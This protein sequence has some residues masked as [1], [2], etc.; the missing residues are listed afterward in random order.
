MRSK[1]YLNMTLA[2]AS[3]LI[4]ASAISP[5][6]RGAPTAVTEKIL[7]FNEFTKLPVPS[8]VMARMKASSLSL[9]PIGNAQHLPTCSGVIIS[10]SGYVLT[11]FHCIYGKNR[12]TKGEISD[13]S[14]KAEF[15]KATIL[16]QGNGT[17]TQFPH[18]K[19]PGFNFKK[20]NEI[21]DDWAIL[22]LPER[23]GGYACSQASIEASEGDSMYHLGFPQEY[24][25]NNSWLKAMLDPAQHE[26]KDKNL[27]ALRK[28]LAEEFQNA[29][30]RGESW[31]MNVAYPLYI[32]LGYNFNSVAA[33]S[34]R[35]PVMSAQSDLDNVIDPKNYGYSTAPIHVGMS[36][37]GAFS[38]DT[39]HLVGLN[40]FTFGDL[41][42]SYA[43]FPYGIGFIKVSNVKNAI[44]KKLGEKLVSQAFDCNPAPKK[45]ATHFIAAE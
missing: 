1:F 23:P 12:N 4:I 30:K 7:A 10:N 8:D 39:G 43:G 35:M 19:S 16:A 27:G 26:F 9:I 18:S 44:R 31:A 45:A 36:G 37:G 33:A 17:Y 34:K 41:R 29:L 40:V 11:D 13:L 2:G 14:P 3:A 42:M 22:K 6:A 21:F 24:T 38:V 25:M 5:I 20:F 32:S 28:K 15:A